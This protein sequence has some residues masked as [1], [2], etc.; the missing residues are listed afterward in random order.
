[1]TVK[2]R[3]AHLFGGEHH[4]LQ[5]VSACVI[6][7]TFL[8]V[9][10]F[11]EIVHGQAYLDSDQLLSLLPHHR[12]IFRHADPQAAYLW[13]NKIMFGYSYS[14]SVML[15]FFHFPDNLLL[16]LLAAETASTWGLVFH[17]GLSL[18]FSFLFSRRIGIS[19]AGAATAAIT[20]TFSGIIT[21]NYSHYNDVAMM[22]TLPLM[23]WAAECAVSTG[24]LRWFALLGLV[25]GNNLAFGHP[26]YSLY[27]LLALA[28]YAAVR[29]RTRHALSRRSLI[30]G[31]LL[32]VT[33]VA[34]A[35]PYVLPLL[36]RLLEVSAR[37]QHLPGEGVNNARNP[38]ALALLYLSPLSVASDLPHT[39]EPP[40]LGVHSWLVAFYVGLPALFLLPCAVGQRDRTPQVP[41]GFFWSL[42]GAGWIAFLA[43]MHWN[44]WSLLTLLDHIPVL[45]WFHFHTRSIFL[46]S[47]ATAVL[48]GTGLDRLVRRPAERAGRVHAFAAGVLLVALAMSAARA[49]LGGLLF[50]AA[51]GWLQAASGGRFAEHL[52][53]GSWMSIVG[54][55]IGLVTWSLRRGFVS[56]T[57]FVLFVW[58]TAFIDLML[59]GL[60]Y[61]PTLSPRSVLD[62]P[63]FARVLT[64]TDARVFS[65][66]PAPYFYDRRLPPTVRRRSL[67]TNLNLLYGIEEVGG[68]TT[69]SGTPAFY[70]Y[71]RH[72]GIRV[73]YQR[74]GWAPFPPVDLQSQAPLLRA[75]SITHVITATAPPAADFAVIARD[76]DLFLSE[77][78]D[79]GPRAYA[80][81]ALVKA[82]SP[83]D[84]VSRLPTIG[85]LRTTAIVY[86]P[87]SR[88]AE[89]YGPASVR[90]LLRDAT[91]ATLEVVSSS[92]GFV[93]LTDAYDRNWTAEIDGSSTA[94]F[95]TNG[96]F[97][98]AVVPPGRHL[99]RFEYQDKHFEFGLAVRRAA[100]GLLLILFVLG[101]LRWRGSRFP[102]G[103]AA[104]G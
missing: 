22:L 102:P 59:F 41:L 37:G 40:V 56:V 85:D 43:P 35:T 10:F 30:H 81:R 27:E 13:T 18:A 26:Q 90:V 86:D 80:V 79:P 74:E 51:W 93:V 75:A 48:A 58:F 62:P 1:L 31:S 97:R 84:A 57:T 38:L 92:E 34:I 65:A 96:I 98:G 29:L 55:A 83:L 39:A 63:E 25:V 33:G 19:P 78:R 5:R 23:L 73:P 61:K 68:Y 15:S 100:L 16:R 76:Q 17:F 11:H 87:E 67:A 89:R 9:Y 20:F 42:T 95:Q 8:L 32:L 101:V 60:P 12:E 21:S 77:I 52:S 2:S 7:S 36:A 71:V 69:P 6:A 4:R 28:A 45:N 70:R 53:L 54:I 49:G 99:L 14:R 82:V 44:G 47:F 3:V 46:G 24:H 103:R 66:V 64:S 94:V 88:L 91:R 104:T 72:L 50:P